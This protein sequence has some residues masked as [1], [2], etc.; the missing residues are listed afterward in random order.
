MDI[1]FIKRA[2]VVQRWGLD[3][4]V[5]DNWYTSLQVFGFFRSRTI[6]ASLFSRF[7]KTAASPFLGCD[8]ILGQDLLGDQM[9]ITA[10]LFVRFSG[11]TIFRGERQEVRQGRRL[12]LWKV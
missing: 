10:L 6:T 2:R 3:C 1:S 11:E 5:G 9:Y 4:R 12:R 8:Q 7:F